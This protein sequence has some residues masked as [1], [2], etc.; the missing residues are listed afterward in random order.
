MQHAG[1]GEPTH[2]M[3]VLITWIFPDSSGKKQGCLP[4]LDVVQATVKASPSVTSDFCIAA[5]FFQH[6][7]SA[8]M[9]CLP[10]PLHL[11][12]DRQTY[13]HRG[14]THVLPDSVC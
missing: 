7:L 11:S 2:H 6:F 3:M 10:F 13:T 14:T 5:K 1:D 4:V 12:Q 9:K 8:T